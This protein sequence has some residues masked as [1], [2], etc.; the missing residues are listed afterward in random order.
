LVSEQTAAL[1]ALRLESIIAGYSGNEVLHGVSM[2][3]NSG[4]VA[5]ILG[6]NGAGKSTML[7]V[8]VGMVKPRSGRVLLNGDDVSNL[9]VHLR[10][11]RGIALVPEGRRVFKR[12]SVGDNLLLGTVAASGDRH[13]REQAFAWVWEL[14]PVLERKRNKLAATLSGGE[15][16]MLAIAQGVMSNPKVLLLDEP[17]AGLSPLL[18]KQVLSRVKLLKERGI[19]VVIVEQIVSALDVADHVYIVRNGQVVQEGAASEMHAEDLSSQ[20]LSSASTDARA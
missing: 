17:S 15:Q 10:A 5:L 3:A 8:G 4:E 14:F 9:P 19:A 7:A 13:W 11:R 20:Y 12:Q 16:Q 2:D 1:P 18:A 6:P